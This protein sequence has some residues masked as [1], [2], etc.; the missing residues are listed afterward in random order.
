LTLFIGCVPALATPTP[1]PP[2]DPNA[3]NVSIAQTAEAASAQTLAAVPPSTLTAT[4]TPTPRNTFTP[5]STFTPVQTILFPSPEP[6]LRLQYYRVKHDDQLAMYN[7]KSRTFDD[8]SDGL[9]RQTPEV[10]PLFVLP[11]EGSG[12]ARTS[13]TGGWG[14][15]IDALNNYDHN[16]LGYLKNSATALFNTA[17]FPQLES[18]TMGGNII[19]LDEVRGDWGRVHTLDY[20]TPPNAVDFNYFTNPDLIHKFVVVGWKRA[21]KSTILVKPP[22]GD[23]Y[24][25]LVTKRRVWIPMERLE[26]FPTLPLVVTANIDL[27]IQTTPGPNLEKTRFKVSAEQSTKIIAYHPSGPD[28]WGRVQTGG[29]I[30]LLLNRQY[31]TSWTM[32]TVPPP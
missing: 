19:R 1:I 20:G 16:K 7:Y 6:V 9:R 25:P 26:P 22:K 4:V 21:T 30:P 28:V 27:Y 3:I 29:W 31:L 11:E 23:L 13:L 14:T 12:T 8:N 5:E 24:W 18:L 15:L 32:E 17:G 10:V 2:L